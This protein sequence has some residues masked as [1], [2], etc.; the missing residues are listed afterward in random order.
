MRFAQTLIERNKVM[1][2]ISQPAPSFMFACP[3]SSDEHADTVIQIR[4]VKGARMSG[5]IRAGVSVV[6]IPANDRGRMLLT[7]ALCL[8]L[9]DVHINGQP[10]RP[11]GVG[12]TFIPDSGVRER[13]FGGPAAVILGVPGRFNASGLSREGLTDSARRILA[14]L[15]YALAPVYV[16]DERAAA[17][18]VQHQRD[19]YAAAQRNLN[20]A[21]EVAAAK[22]AD[23]FAATERL[24]AIVAG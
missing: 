10:V 21:K 16:T 5:T 15:S 13:A 6:D 23:L 24:N 22:Y 14:A 9:T 7:P 2:A 19:E 20:R 4:P 3:A 12:A 1:N 18:H 17:A 11:L 8:V